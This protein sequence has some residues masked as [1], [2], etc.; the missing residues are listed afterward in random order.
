M[1][2]LEKLEKVLAFYEQQLDII[3]A[4]FQ[5]QANNVAAKHANSQRLKEQMDATQQQS[6]NAQPTA[7]ALQL[8][9]YLMES[10]ENDIR[11]NDIELNAAMEQLETQ[12][13]ELR[14]QISKIDALEKVVA[15]KSRDIEYLRRQTE[16]RLADER[17]LNTHFNGSLK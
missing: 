3:K 10:I 1:N 14:T 9:A 12:R 7:F 2:Q 17:Y 6:S 11:K 8:T 4:K 13:T 16:Q 5:R 15:K